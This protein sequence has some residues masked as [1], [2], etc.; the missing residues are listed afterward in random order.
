MNQALKYL[1]VPYAKKYHEKGCKYRSI[2]FVLCIFRKT[3]C[4]STRSAKTRDV[5][6][7]SKVG[8]GSRHSELLIGNFPLFVISGGMCPLCPKIATS[9][10]KM[11][12]RGLGKTHG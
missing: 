10:A 9:L 12:C 4:P 6:N 5:G 1:G 8:K 3:D 2:C 11:L 7:I